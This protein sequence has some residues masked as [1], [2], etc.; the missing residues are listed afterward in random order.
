MKKFKLISK[1]E[2]VLADTYTPVGLYLALR[3]KY[4]GSLL[5]ESSD[6]H[7]A[8]NSSSFI[9]I[10]PIASFSVMDEQLELCYPGGGTEKRALS[11]RH[12]IMNELRV[13]RGKFNTASNPE[14]KYC[15]LFGYTG[16][17]AVKYFEDTRSVANTDRKK[18]IPLMHYA[19]Y[20]FV[21]VIDH[22]K[23]EMT[24][25]QNIIDDYENT[26]ELALLKNHL[27]NKGINRFS[28]SKEGMERSNIT[29]DD[30]TARVR[31]GKEQCR[32]GNV[33]QVVLSR[34][35]EQD[36]TGDEFNVYRALRSINPSPYL[37]FFEYNNF[38]I[39]GS[40]PEAQLVVKNRIAEIHPIAGTVKRT[41]SERKDEELALA[42]KK[43]EKEMAEHVMLVDLARNDLSR[44]CNEVTVE[45]FSETQYFSHVIHLVSKVT[46]K[47]KDKNDALHIFANTFP[48]GT[49]SGAPKHRAMQLISNCENDE[50]GYY[51]GAIGYFGFD[52][53]VNHA[54]IIRSFL[55][56]NNTLY[57][58]AGAGVVIAS[59]DENELQEVN[60]KLAALRSA[61][62][63]AEK[64]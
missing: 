16:Y 23:D 36:F 3:D 42:L 20:R 1:S 53:E 17:E 61:L 58:R 54:I 63:M 49:L 59:N 48:A 22:F 50:R 4:P 19:L 18:S 55:S 46:G 29:D 33:F 6:Y 12:V 27:R 24:L 32:K 8:E 51:G 30:F 43:D 60:N 34:E 25:V 11:Y 52:G 57:Y 40:S 7:G 62:E 41:G 13:F 15:G 10:D 64:I 2:K 47:L 35:F 56:M 14:K 31:N 21:I 9:C 5:L 26:A 37:F 38:R 45:V 39:F 44:S 28:F